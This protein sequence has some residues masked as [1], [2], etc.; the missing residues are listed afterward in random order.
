MRLLKSMYSLPL[1]GN[2]FSIYVAWN[3]NLIYCMPILKCSIDCNTE[4]ACKEH[5]LLISCKFPLGKYNVCSTNNTPTNYAG[6]L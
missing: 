2:I 6:I 4:V 5:V 3:M 1:K